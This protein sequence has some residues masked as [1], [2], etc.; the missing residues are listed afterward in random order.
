MHTHIPVHF[1]FKTSAS[2][3]HFYIRTLPHIFFNPSS[4]THIFCPHFPYLSVKTHIK[5][6]L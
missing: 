4:N 5:P 3:F 6:T 2:S 1:S